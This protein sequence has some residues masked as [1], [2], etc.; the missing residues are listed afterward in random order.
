[1]V[2]KASTDAGA[3]FVKDLCEFYIYSFSEDW[4]KWN[5]PFEKLDK[6]IPFKMFWT[7]IKDL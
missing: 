5:I 4:I 2:L 7:L 3:Y 1:L 6:N